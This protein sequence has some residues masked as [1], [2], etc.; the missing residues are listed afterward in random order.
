M[1]EPVTAVT[2]ASVCSEVLTILRNHSQGDDSP[3]ILDEL[4]NVTVRELDDGAAI[5]RRDTVSNVQQAA[6]VSGTAL[7]D[8][9]NFVRDNWKGG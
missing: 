7:N 9:A 5:D 6:A 8:P 4:N 2:N 1:Q 3:G